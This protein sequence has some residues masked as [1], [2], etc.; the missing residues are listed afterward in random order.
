M[1]AGE[2]DQCLVIDT[3]CLQ[4][5]N[6]SGQALIDSGTRLVVLS[7]FAAGF[8]GIGQETRHWHVGGVEEDFLDPLM[9]AAV[10]LV[11]EQIGLEIKR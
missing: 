7:Q 8:R 6:Q 3:R 4:D 1:I 9:A 5:R 2:Q 11:A 10:G